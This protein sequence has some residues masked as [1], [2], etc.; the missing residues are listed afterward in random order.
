MKPIAYLVAIAV[1]I[2]G[3]TA[4]ATDLPAGKQAAAALGDPARDRA[5]LIA[6]LKQEPLE[7]GN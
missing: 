4:L 7:T 2:A 3:L 5:D 6:S 1:Q